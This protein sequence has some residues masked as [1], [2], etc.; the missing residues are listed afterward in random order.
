MSYRGFGGY[1]GAAGDYFVPVYRRRRYRGD[2]FDPTG[3]DTS[4]DPSSIDTGA[5]V[6][7]SSGTPDF[8][9]VTGGSSSV[10]MP[11]VS[12]MGF[13]GLPSIAGVGG[14]IQ[15]FLG[16]ANQLAPSFGPGVGAGGLA[17]VAPTVKKMAKRLMSHLRGGGGRHH[18][19]N[20]G[21]FKALRRSMRRLKSF[22]HAAKRVYSFTH[23]APGRAKFKFPRRKRH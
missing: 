4:F 17:A 23:R 9:D 10:T 13:P 21:N 22:E 2:A 15:K 12:A 18:R 7:T 8:S 3:I 20:P 11:D 16:G 19:M 14:A 5:G 6:D 1:Q